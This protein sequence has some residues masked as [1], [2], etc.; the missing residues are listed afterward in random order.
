MP[1]RYGGRIARPPGIEQLKQL[2]AGG[3]VVEG[4]I[5][6]DD[7]EKLIER[8]LPVAFRVQ[9][10][11]EIEAALAII[12]IGGKLGA[13]RLGVAGARGFARKLEARPGARHRCAVG[14]CRRHQSQGLLGT[15]QISGLD[16]TFG[17]ACGGAVILGVLLQRLGEGLRR[18][19]GVARGKR[20]VCL[21]KV[22][23]RVG[24]LIADQAR[25]ERFDARTQAALP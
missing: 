4:A 12:G 20:F 25:D 3:V 11:G 21:V 2:L 1:A 22:C 16:V 13:E 8:A 5:L 6:A 23:R 10:D 24:A 15:G 7:G 17:E 9:R 14:L 19:V 18:G